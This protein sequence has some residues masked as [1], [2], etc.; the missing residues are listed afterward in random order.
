MTANVFDIFEE[1]PY[2]EDLTRMF[3]AGRLGNL[4]EARE[5]RNALD[6]RIKRN[7]ELERTILESRRHSVNLNPMRPTVATET[8]QIIEENFDIAARHRLMGMPFLVLKIG[9]YTDFLQ[10]QQ[11]ADL[12]QW[13]SNILDYNCIGGLLRARAAFWTLTAEKQAKAVS[14]W[15]ARFNSDPNSAVQDADGQPGATVQPKAVAGSG[16]K[17]STETASANQNPTCEVTDPDRSTGTPSANQNPNP[18]PEATKDLSIPGPVRFRLTNI[19]EP[20]WQILM[21]ETST[22]I[23]SEPATISVPVSTVGLSEKQFASIQT[24]EVFD[25]LNRWAREHL[26]I[27]GLRGRPNKKET[28][29]VIQQWKNEGSPTPCPTLVLD[30]I[31][32]VVFAA[33]LEG[34]QPGS[35]QHTRVRERVRLLLK[36]RAYPPT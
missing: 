27:K 5:L 19:P 9:Q 10:R 7:T 34:T 12:A 18:E 8:Q 33:E 11:E 36:R 24:R 13:D 23:E 4:A 1:N 16:R 20:E 14:K 3:S 2:L 17:E 31:G 35:L 22:A 25:L 29:S 21:P 6:A 15:I 26:K 30:K 28:A 32:K